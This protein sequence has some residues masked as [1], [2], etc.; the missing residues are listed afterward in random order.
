MGELKVK[1]SDETEKKFREAA[2]HEFGFQK[3][4]LSIA[5]DKALSNWA[6]KH[7]DLD[8]LRKIA[9]EKIK[10]PVSS[11]RG[12]LK[13]VKMSSIDLQHEISNMR[14]KRWKTHAN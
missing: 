12:V 2:M 13:H 11:M 8:R 6:R 3:G 4:S 5:A 1:I 14:V 7:E 10:D 9:R